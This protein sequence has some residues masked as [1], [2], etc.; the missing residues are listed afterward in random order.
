[1]EMGW[2][3]ILAA[4][5]VATAVALRFVTYTMLVKFN[6]WLPE[7]AKKIANLSSCIIALIALLVIVGKA[8]VSPH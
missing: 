4:A 7:K 8:I 2:Y 5:A 1:M 3:A 6:R